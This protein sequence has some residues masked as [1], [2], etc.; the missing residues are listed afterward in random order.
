MAL[1][2]KLTAIGDA[3]REKTGGTELLT[4]DE[5]PVAISGIET[6]GGSVSGELPEEAFDFSGNATYMFAN[7]HWDWFIRDYGDKIIT[8]EINDMSRMFDKSQVTEIPFTINGKMSEYYTMQYMFSGCS[9][10]TTVPYVIGYPSSINGI[11]NDCVRLKEIP[12][13]WADN[14]NWDRLHTYSSGNISSVFSGCYSLRKIPQSIM[15]NLWGIQTSASYQPYNGMFQSC[16]S[17]D[18]A[19]DIPVQSK[20]IT[21]NSFSSTFSTNFRNKKIT[22]ATDDNVAKTANWKSQTIDLSSYIGYASNDSYLRNYA[23]FTTATSVTD[24]TTYEALKD[25][26]DWWTTNI[27]YARYNHDSAVETINS[28][29]DTSEYLTANGGTNTIKFKGAAGELTD[30]GAINTL[31]EE[32]IAVATAKGWTVTLV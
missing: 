8:S 15:S 14:I 24:A 18:E 3:I 29:P 7:K 4:L 1:T 13:D 9:Y 32:E 11:F 27:S 31:T 30:G 2:D 26:P 5:M 25:N 22:F 6:G 20:N 28:L 19:I 12:E 21:S 16:Q 17:L 23:G 10:I